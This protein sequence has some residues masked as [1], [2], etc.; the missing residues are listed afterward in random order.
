M[1]RRKR[2]TNAGK[3]LGKIDGKY[4]SECFVCGNKFP[5]STPKNTETFAEHKRKYF[6]KYSLEKLKKKIRPKSS[7]DRILM[8][9]SFAENERSLEKRREN[10]NVELYAARRVQ[11]ALREVMKESDEE[12]TD[13]EETDTEETDTEETDITKP[14]ENDEIATNSEQNA[15]I[16]KPM[17]ELKLADDENERVHRTHRADDFTKESKHHLVQK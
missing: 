3:S 8:E 6:N 13:S 7:D 15:A 12:E 17:E 2:G 11:Y 9:S 10:I 16:V 4:W 14:F 5:N 1:P